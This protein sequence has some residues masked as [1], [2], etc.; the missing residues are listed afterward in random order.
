MKVL[1]CVVT[2]KVMDAQQSADPYPFAVG[3][4]WI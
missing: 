3:N 2:A 4:Y 1:G